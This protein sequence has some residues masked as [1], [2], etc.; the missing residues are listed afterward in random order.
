MDFFAR[1]AQARRLSSTLVLLFAGSVL[2]VVLA[3]NLVVLTVVASLQAEIPG[4]VVPDGAWLRAHPG[5]ALFTT[6]AVVGVIG[7]ASAYKSSALSEGGGAV[8]R[9][10]GGVPVTADCTDPL[11]RRLRNVVEEMAIASG[12]PTPE[13]FLL[14]HEPGINAFAAGHH[15]ANAAVAVTRGALERLSRDELQG[16][17]AHEFSHILNGDMRLSIRLMGLLFGLLVIALVARTVLRF[18]PRGGRGRGA[19]GAAVL[20]AA[21]LAVLVIGYVG[22]F[23]GR[24]IQA[25]VSRGRESLADASAVQ[26]TRDP[27]GLRGAL[28]KIAALTEGSRI[29][30]AEA[31]EVAHML[32]APGMGRLFA[33]HPP[34]RSRLRALDP[35][36][37]P[38]E[39]AAVRA[40]MAE[41]PPPAAAEPA[42]REA[43]AARLSPLVQAS[44]AAVPEA[45]ARQVGS[46]VTAHVRRAREIRDS[47]PPAVAHAGEAPQ[48]AVAV[49]LALALAADAEARRRQLLVVERQL[50]AD[51]SA[52]VARVA[53]EVEGLE[54]AQRL[55]ALLRLFPALH[56]LARRD[57]QRLLA[58][59]SALLPWG[60]G[61]PSVHHYALSKLAQVHLRDD[62]TPRAETRRPLALD[63]VREELAVLF[64]VL[65]QHGDA[66]PAAAERAFAAGIAHLLRHGPPPYRPRPDWPARLDRAFDRLDRLAPGA[67]QRVV[68]A[69]V[70]TISHDGR[71]TPAEAELLRT[72]SAVL[73]CPLPPLLDEGGA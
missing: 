43:A 58:C 7:L 54:P 56:Q 72:V 32:F 11:R 63:D 69:L 67:K 42:P 31:E 25:A 48:E 16:V 49:L 45:I 21:A 70:K 8:A 13:V 60:E 37:D 17:I 73:H 26:F 18:A 53:P 27:S 65:A 40:R 46:P 20:I 29:V 9:A 52:A 51:V 15:P 38:K 34:I 59:V 66:D 50:G 36:F 19:G 41:A 55:P 2:A 39:I 14:E 28:V 33:T 10:L 3:V 4:I 22:L 68:E 64:S 24:L 57:R 12:V 62:L 61:R 47:L 71:L 35:R 1:Q 30:D 23:F 6:L 5:V 44:V